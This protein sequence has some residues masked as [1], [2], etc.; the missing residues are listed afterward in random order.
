MGGGG[1]GQGDEYTPGGVFTRTKTFVNSAL[2]V[3][4]EILSTLKVKN[5]L[6]RG[7]PFQKESERFDRE[8]SLES[9]SH[10]VCS[11]QSITI[12]H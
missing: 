12:I 11:P 3:P 9:V 6:P 5:L 8:I 10:S 2:H 7:T 1:A 4:F